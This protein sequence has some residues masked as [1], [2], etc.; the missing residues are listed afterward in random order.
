MAFR[1]PCFQSVAAWFGETHYIET[2]DLRFVADKETGAGTCR[3]N[4]HAVVT[5]SIT[6]M[7]GQ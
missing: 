5:T 6:I 3:V 1:S 7:R 2:F 4:A